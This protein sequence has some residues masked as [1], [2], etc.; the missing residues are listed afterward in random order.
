MKTTEPVTPPCP[1]PTKPKATA[2]LRRLALQDM[3]DLATGKITVKQARERNAYAAKLM[4]KLKR[5][6][7]GKS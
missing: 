4:R 2:D 3:T 1:W 6:I 5:S 7:S